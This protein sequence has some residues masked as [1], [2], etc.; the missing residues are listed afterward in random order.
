M[1]TNVN[2]QRRETKTYEVDPR[3]SVDN[4]EVQVLIDKTGVHVLHYDGAA[5]W[6]TRRYYQTKPVPLELVKLALEW[7]EEIR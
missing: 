5:N 1:K 4:G 6:F 7:W 3:V 2:V